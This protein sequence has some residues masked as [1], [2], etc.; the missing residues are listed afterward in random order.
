MKIKQLPWEHNPDSMVD[1]YG[2]QLGS[3][4]A[5]VYTLESGWAAE[6]YYS[7]EYD[8]SQYEDFDTE[9]EAKQYAQN[10]FEE[11]AKATIN[12]LIET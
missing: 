11:Y 4:M 7:D 2:A 10:L 3:F 1:G 12:E 8:M 6:V 5:D 9:S